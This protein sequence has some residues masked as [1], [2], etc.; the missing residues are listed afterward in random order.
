MKN[1]NR[2]RALEKQITPKVPMMVDAI[3]ADGVVRKMPI[4]EMVTTGAVFAG[5]IYPDNY[6]LD[7]LQVYLDYMK[8]V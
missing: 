4:R 7:D 3:C 2:I 5:K 1:T 6:A 8:T